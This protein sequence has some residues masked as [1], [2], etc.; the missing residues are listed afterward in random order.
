ML[1]CACFKLLKTMHTLFAFGLFKGIIHKDK[2]LVDGV[3][4][5]LR[6]QAPPYATQLSSIITLPIPSE[7]PSPIFLLD[8]PVYHQHLLIFL[9]CSCSFPI[10]NIFGAF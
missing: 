2:A 9:T 5:Q 7:I 8:L 10:C 4:S 1:D 3:M 6:C